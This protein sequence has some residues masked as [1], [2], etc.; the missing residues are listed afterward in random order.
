MVLS[1]L[2]NAA[3]AACLVLTVPALAQTPPAGLP[4]VVVAPAAL[5]AISDS[6]DFLGRIQAAEKVELRARVEGFITE[7]RF[8]EGQMVKQGELLCVFV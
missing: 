8:K 3:L 5:Q 7:Q 2:R 4:A 6:A 1:G